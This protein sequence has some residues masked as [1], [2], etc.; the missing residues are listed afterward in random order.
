MGQINMHPD[1]FRLL[2]YKAV[3]LIADNLQQ[4][5]QSV[6]RQ[7]VPAALRDAIMSE[8]LPQDGLDA[9]E[10]V[11]RFANEVQP[12]PMGN[13]SPRFMGWVNST[14]A[15]LGFIA[16]LL[17][18][19]LDPSVAGGDHAATYVEHAVLRWMKEIMRFPADAGAVLVSG[20]SVANL[21]CLGAMRHAVTN[22]KDR[23]EG[24]NAAGAPMTLYTSTEGHSCIQK[25]IE[26]LGFGSQN[27]RKI[28]VDADFCMDLEALKAQITADRQAG[29]RPVCVIAS[30]GTVNTGALD[31]FADLADLCT[32]EKLW[33]HLDASYGGVGILAEQT[34]SYYTGIERADSIAMDQ[35]K[36]MYIPVECGCALVKDAR[37]M[38]DTY[39]LVPDYLRDDR[40]LPWFSEFSIQQ[41][42]GFRALKLW[43]VLQQVGVNGYRKLIDQNITLA[44]SLAEKIRAHPEFELVAKGPLSIV[45]FRYTPQGLAGDD[46]QAIDALN[47]RLV[48]I[49]MNGGQAFLTS[50]ELNGRPV[51]RACIVNFRTTEADLNA[52]LEAVLSAAEQLDAE[53]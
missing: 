38:R 27:L 8:P 13:S 20:G 23:A 11:E 5:D 43:M 29:F 18:A 12:Y 10:L 22:G 39:S 19:S 53:G 7:P 42:R 24:L 47:R 31:P 4:L 48:P 51:L 40:S 9:I 21:T 25:A 52:V 34:A 35:H 16:E 28:P 15:P 2:G 6:V 1:E 30:A 14:P 45:C 3:D 37:L 33:L 26:I 36:W 49:I 50:A 44:N 17:A 41:T 32:E 46:T